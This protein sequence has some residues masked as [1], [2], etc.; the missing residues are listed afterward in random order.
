MIG[1]AF[2][3]AELAGWQW[4]GKGDLKRAM[5]A[6]HIADGDR[7][8]QIP[9]SHYF[10]CREIDCVLWKIAASPTFVVALLRE[11]LGIVGSFCMLVTLQPNNSPSLV[12]VKIKCPNSRENINTR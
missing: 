10:L 8:K 12:P 11:R 9:K 3:D 2:V 7:G 6:G 5:L 4:R 1:L